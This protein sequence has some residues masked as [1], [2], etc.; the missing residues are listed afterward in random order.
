MGNLTPEM[1]AIFATTLS[2][3]ILSPG[4]GVISV[5]QAA[6]AMGRTRALPYGWGLAFGASLWCLFSLLGLSVLFRIVPALFVALKIAGGAYLLWIGWKMWKGAR[7]PLPDPADK[8]FGTGFWGG[9]ALNL[10]NPKPALFYSAVLL[11]IFPKDL[12]AGA[13]ALI[14]LTA[15]AIETGFYTALATIM[16]LPLLRQRYY[17]AK[18]WIDRVTALCLGALGL[19]L[20]VRH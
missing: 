13:Q 6:F 16:S 18:L 17:S 4:P 5:T 19:S 3:A 15:L 14:Y 2:L 7:D 8:R 12:T 9:M 10:S 11:S 20:I 1:F